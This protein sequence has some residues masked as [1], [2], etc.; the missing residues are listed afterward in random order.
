MWADVIKCLNALL[1]SARSFH[2]SCLN[3]SMSTCNKYFITFDRDKY[4]TN[5]DDARYP[6]WF[7]LSHLFFFFNF[8]FYEL[9]D[10]ISNG[11]PCSMLFR[12][13]MYDVAVS[14]VAGKLCELAN[15]NPN[16]TESDMLWYHNPNTHQDQL[17]ATFGNNTTE[18]VPKYS[19][20]RE[21]V[22]YTCVDST[23]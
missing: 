5:R 22:K 23:L 7:K 6:S 9:C 1:E 21:L 2:S 10:A 18:W 3:P 14:L 4:S 11:M 20:D 17:I 16:L 13:S 12:R 19:R 8:I 15:A